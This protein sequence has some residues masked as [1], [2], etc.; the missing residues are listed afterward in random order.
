MVAQSFGAVGYAECPRCSGL[1]LTRESFDA[2]QKDADTRT[3]VRLAEPP[4][5][6]KPG[7]VLGPVRYRACPSCRK[8]MNRLNFA[9][10][11][12]IV[13]D[14]CRDHG[15]WFDRGELA[16]IVAFLENGGWD[17][18]KKRER[19][20]LQEEVRSLERAKEFQ[21]SIEL[22]TSRAD[23]ELRGLGT[24]LDVA[25]FLGGLFRK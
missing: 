14:A 10:G 7:E 15:F 4:L 20:R 24:L 13:I 6:R 18:V 9:G 11:S 8:L 5:E 19:E 1:F 17:K 16:A 25:G 23:Q 3:K 2:V 21:R 22:P 12:G